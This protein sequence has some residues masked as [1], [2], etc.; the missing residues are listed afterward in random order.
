MSTLAHETPESPAPAPAPE[1]TEQ[2]QEF[3][4]ALRA[5]ELHGHI[6]ASVYELGCAETKA[7]LA[8]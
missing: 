5:G 3:V 8:A 4:R 1:L 2:Q 7:R 6:M